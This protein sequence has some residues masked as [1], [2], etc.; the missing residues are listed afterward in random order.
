MCQ[1]IFIPLTRRPVAF[2]RVA[3]GR[4]NQPGKRKK[5]PM[6]VE[7]KFTIPDRAT[8]ERLRHLDHLLGYHVEPGGIKQVDD[9]YLDTDDRAILAAGYACRLRRVKHVPERQAAPTLIA[10]LKSLST[11]ETETSIHQREEYEVEVPDADPDNWPESTARELALELAQGRPLSEMFSL[12]QERHYRQLVLDG[13][14]GQRTMA[15]LTVDSVTPGVSGAQPYYELEI[16]LL[17]QGTAGELRALADA[18]QAAWQ[19]QPQPLSKFER[20]LA[21][22]DERAGQK[23]NPSTSRGLLSREQRIQLQRWLKAGNRPEQRRARILLLWDSGKDTQ[24]IAAE[25]GLSR[26]QVRRWLAAFRERG[27]EVFPFTPQETNEGVAQR[28]APPPTDEMPGNPPAPD[29]IELPPTPALSAAHVGDLEAEELPEL[30][31]PGLLP[32]DPMA[33]AGRK[34]LWFHF[35]RMLKHE[36]GTRAGKDIEELHDMRVAT[37]RMRAAIRVFGDYL[38]PKVI[39]PFN[40]HV[41]QVGRALGPV[42]DLDVFE[43]K[44][45]HYLQT[46]PEEARQ[47]LD[48]LIETWHNERKAARE[49]MIGYLDG[50]AY[51]KFKKEFAVFLQTKGAGAIAIPRNRPIPF[52]VRHVAPRLIYTRY[53]A[54][55]AYDTVIENAQ[56][57]T[58][59]ALRIDC[60]YL[61]YTLE[62]LKE[63]LA[64]EG[65]RV[66][67]E[68]KAMQDHLGDLNDAD[69]AIGLL[70]DFLKEWDAIEINVP[71]A[72][73][74]S[75]EG[76]ANYLAA[77]HAEKHRLLV[78]F[79]AAWERLNRDEVRHWLALAVAAL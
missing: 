32:D 4:A 23:S 45:G 24:A 52:Q 63:V 10:T 18:L 12:H 62:F 6:E 68:I 36:P 1:P 58:L 57:E 17:Q 33:E 34:T 29:R 74:R 48:P 70:N 75:V 22:T 14:D 11:A 5:G 47:G 25:V 9:R 16:E 2:K 71:L 56:I 60:K 69:V 39:K 13:P 72:Q 30:D 38:E 54:V 8:F 31:T 3:L 35:L 46:L 50:P 19:L 78:T 59:H 42:R 49:K 7:A 77:R 21:L 41:R 37:R 20:A 65:E 44:A 43:E 27:L 53:E 28:D 76:V 79:P 51:G 15:E 40:K 67:K 55:R 66:I 64:P 73:R 61:R 26:R